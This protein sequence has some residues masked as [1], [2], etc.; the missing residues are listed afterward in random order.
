MSAVNSEFDYLQSEVSRSIDIL[1]S[2][3]QSNKRKTSWIN[4]ISISLGALITVTLGID[5]SSEYIELQKNIALILGSLLTLT[6]SWNAC[7]D[8]KKLWIRQKTTLLALYQIKNE[9]GYR[10]SKAEKTKIDDIF[11]EYQRIWEQDSNEWRNITQPTSIC[12]KDSS[13]D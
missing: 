5:V 13:K 6:S 3:A 8:Y 4:A 1:K 10:A 2:K 7:F 12:N 11:D 9:L